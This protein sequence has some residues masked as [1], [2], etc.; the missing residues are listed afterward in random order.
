[1][2]EIVQLRVG[3]ETLFAGHKGRRFGKFR[4]TFCQNWA[5]LLKASGRSDT[6]SE[7][8][9]IRNLERLNIS[10]LPTHCTASKHQSQFAAA[11]L[12]NG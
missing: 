5:V 12:V 10:L 9:L 4:P 7:D 2:A 6:D 1:M 8:R 3:F 11:A